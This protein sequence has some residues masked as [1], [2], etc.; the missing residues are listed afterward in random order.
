MDKI[1]KYLSSYGA[2]V[3]YEDLSPEVV[4]KTKGLLLDSL[5]CAMGGYSSEPAKIAR[6]MAERIHDSEIPATLIG[7]GQKTSPEA[8]AFANGI[9]IRYLDFNDTFATVGGGHPS[10]NFTPVLTLGDAIHA[11]GKELLVSAVLAY[12]VMCRIGDQIN[13]GA[14]GIDH[15][16]TGVMS[17]VMG[18]SRILRLS[19]EQIAQAINLAVAPNV[20]LAQTR[21]GEVSMWKGCAMANA[22]RNAVFAALLAKERMTGPSPV[23]E[24][25][26]GFFNAIS[27]P[28]QLDKFGGK[29]RPFRILDVSIKKYP[30]GNL[31]QTAIDAAVTLRSKVK[32]MD[33]IA[34][35][36]IETFEHAMNTMGGD[37]EKWH[38]KTRET[39]DHSLP[40]VICVGLMYG[41]LEKRHFDDE[42]LQNP[43]LLA[44]IQKVKITVTE[45]CNKL[46]PSAHPVRMQIVTKSGKKFSEMVLHWRGHYK[47]PLPDKEIEDKF[48]SLSRDLLLPEQR[49]ELTSLVWN[50]EKVKDVSRIMELLKI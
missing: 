6:R 28:F 43:E 32:N 3:K 44:L 22:A 30:C 29:D 45:E 7:S 35:I 41:T 8:A 38:P 20:T 40:Y 47:N 2:S 37:V 49:Q 13:F 42:Y 39:A 25:R 50:M 15:S 10:D 9:M 11:S 1:T 16:T 27:G 36:N 23:F 48:N 14:K 17:C 34:E 46:R 31:A 24:G 4:H 12:E 21:V 33:E 18:A 26:Y 5:G 19:K